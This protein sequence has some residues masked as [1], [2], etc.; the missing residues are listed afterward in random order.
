VPTLNN[1]GSVAAD[2]LRLNTGVPACT[3]DSPVDQVGSCRFIGAFFN[4]TDAVADLQA[5]PN[6]RRL[7]DDV[8]DM[9]IR[10]VA[11]G[12]GPL[13]HSIFPTVLKDLS[14][15]DIVGDGVDANDNSFLGSFPYVA[16]PNQG[17]SHE[18]HGP[19]LL[20]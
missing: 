12:Y 13:L 4:G 17:Y 19:G 7:G 15:N 18:H 3:A 1:T 11:E 9:E 6:G 10:A 20:F 14:P 8:V 16:L 5:W 2:E